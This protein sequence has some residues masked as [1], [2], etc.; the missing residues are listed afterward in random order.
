VL[1]SPLHVYYHLAP[2]DLWP[3]TE[4]FYKEL[5]VTRNRLGSPARPAAGTKKKA[6]ISDEKI[7]E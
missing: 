6:I 2:G 4:I 7:A 1:G 5:E 3:N